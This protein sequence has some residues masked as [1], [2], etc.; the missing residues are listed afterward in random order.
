MYEIVVRI[1]DIEIVMETV[2]D[3]HAATAHVSWHRS[4]GHQAHYR[5]VLKRVA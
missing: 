3:I 4:K 1:G 2:D 5:P